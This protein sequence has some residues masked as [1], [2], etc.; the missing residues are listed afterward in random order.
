MKKPLQIVVRGKTE[1]FAFTFLGDPKYLGEWRAQG[2]D[3]DEVV[4][5][6]PAW[7]VRAGLTRPWIAVQ[8]AWKWLRP[9]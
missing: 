9:F 3:I 4:N 5:N 2:L 1:S 6:I 8:D 7:A